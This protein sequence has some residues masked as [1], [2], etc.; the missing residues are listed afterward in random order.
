ML[1]D[2]RTLVCLLLLPS[3]FDL[4]S[5]FS[6]CEYPSSAMLRST[7]LPIHYTL[8]VL[9]PQKTSL[10]NMHVLTFFYEF[11]SLCLFLKYGKPVPCNHSERSWGGFARLVGWKRFNSL[12][13]GHGSNVDGSNIEHLVWSELRVFTIISRTAQT[14]A[15]AQLEALPIPQR[16]H[17]NTCTF[18]ESTA[19][20]SAP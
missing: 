8:G 6:G 4:C 5:H 16:E 17:M 9:G 10:G 14:P 19:A 11:H 18:K 3:H 12:K 7:C 15:D 13:R 20:A 1:R 2:S